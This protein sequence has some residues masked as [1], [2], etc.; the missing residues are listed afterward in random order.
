MAGSVEVNR[1]MRMAAER[2]KAALYALALRYAAQMEAY[3]KATAKWQDITSMA[4]KGLFG[5]ALPRDKVLLL[6]IAH[7]MDYGVYLELTNQGRYAVLSPT[8]KRFAAD[9][10]EDAQKVVGR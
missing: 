7:S 4:R 3:A 6:R 9:F 10:M 5:Y 8:V 2:Q 1:N